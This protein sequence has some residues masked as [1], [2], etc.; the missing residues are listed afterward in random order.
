MAKGG[1]QDLA[2]GRKDILRIDPSD[3]HVKDGWNCRDRNFNPADDEDMALAASIAEV[4]VKQPLTAIWEDGKAWL[5]DGHRR[6]AAARYAI[7]SLGAEIKSV[8]VQTEDR[9]ASEADRV[10][11]QIVRN[12]GKS[13]T[14]IEQS[15]VYKRLFDL[16]WS[17][18]EIATRIGRT[19]AWVKN[20]LTLNAAPE[21]ITQM[22]RDKEISATLAMSTLK[23]DGG[24]AVERL[25]EAVDKAK[26]SG[27]TRASAKH[28]TAEA[29]IFDEAVQQGGKQVLE[30]FA[31][32][33]RKADAFD[34]LRRLC[35]YVE[36]GSATS[37]NICQD[38]ATKD[39]LVRVGKAF[40]AYDLSFLGAVEAAVE[41]ETEEPEPEI[42]L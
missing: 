28:M 5:T 14:P 30:D 9:Y 32:L 18:A 27:K 10:L 6:L 29:P 16:G 3:L 25:T 42:E 15:R 2:L 39:W 35:G 36:D 37:V 26:A 31:L 21:A 11:S 34:K 8:P 38:D 19:T 40:P 12:N 20:L 33:R 13:L 22:V 23:K 1:I 24:K 4:G 41:P 7:D 17:E